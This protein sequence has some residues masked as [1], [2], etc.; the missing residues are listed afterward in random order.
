MASRRSERSE[1]VR[2]A[3]RAHR[4]ESGVPFCPPVLPSSRPPGFRA[5]GL[6]LSGELLCRR[7]GRHQ[8]QAAVLAY[9]D[10]FWLLGFGAA[11]MVALS[12][13]SGGHP[14]LPH[15]RSPAPLGDPT[16]A[17]GPGMVRPGAPSAPPPPALER[18]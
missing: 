5:S 16:P 10:T 15:A 4:T 2:D 17:E 11:V 18:P 7:H 13:D 12:L 3:K 1:R 6:P 14:P 9:V 8:S